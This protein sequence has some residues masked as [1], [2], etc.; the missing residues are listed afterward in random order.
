MSDTLVSGLN[1]LDLGQAAIDEYLYAGDVAAVVGGEE[2]GGVRHLVRPAIRPIGTAAAKLTLSPST[3]SCVRPVL[4]KMT[5][6]VYPGLTSYSEE[7]N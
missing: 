7:K 4:L 3:R 5:V 6:S 1:C 2:H